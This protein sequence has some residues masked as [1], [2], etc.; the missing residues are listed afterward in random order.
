MESNLS[1]AE[2]KNMEYDNVTLNSRTEIARKAQI[3]PGQ[4]LQAQQ[5]TYH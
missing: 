1:F 3:K 5:T 2:T 4:P